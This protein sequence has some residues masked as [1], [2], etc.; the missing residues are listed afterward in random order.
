MEPNELREELDRSFVDPKS[1]ESFFKEHPFE[2]RRAEVAVEKFFDHAR[3]HSSVPQ[4]RDHNSWRRSAASHSGVEA[5][6]YNR[7]TH[8]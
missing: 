7:E 5:H 2:T 6:V 8:Q 1:N 4:R 3:H